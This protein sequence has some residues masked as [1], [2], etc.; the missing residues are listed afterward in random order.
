MVETIERASDVIHESAKREEF[1]TG[2]YER[3]FPA[4][5]QFIKRHG[6]GPN[7]A[8][9][10][11]QDALMIFYEKKVNNN[12]E[13][14]LTDEAYIFGIVKNLWK[15][16]STHGNTVSLTDSE[17]FINIPEDF[18]STPDSAAIINFLRASGKKCMELLQAFYYN[19]QPLETIRSAFGFSSIRSATVQKFKCIEKVRELVKIKSKTYEDFFE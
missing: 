7:D 10:V 9:D 3:M 13:V 18:Y 16:R 12:L 11:F 8:K 5:A 15:K 14:A 17:S 4:V 6:G 19:R 1:F 2:V